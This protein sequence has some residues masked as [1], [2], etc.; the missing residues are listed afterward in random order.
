MNIKFELALPCFI[1]LST[2]NCS[3][4]SPPPILLDHSLGPVPTSD[5]ICI[6]ICPT[7]AHLLGNI[8]KD[9]NLPK[10]FILCIHQ[11]YI[12]HSTIIYSS[13]PSP[14]LQ[15]YGAMWCMKIGNLDSFLKANPVSESC[16]RQCC[17]FCDHGHWIC[18]FLCCEFARRD[19][20]PF[21]PTS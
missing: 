9:F 10:T 8:E 15:S 12:F 3:A 20:C 1:I 17:F 7:I 4:S 18:L 13:L 19:Y 21:Q 6:F 14:V 5:C 2:A 11:I 16:L